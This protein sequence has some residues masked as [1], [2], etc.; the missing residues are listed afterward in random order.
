MV[1]DMLCFQKVLSSKDLL[2]ERTPKIGRRH[3]DGRNRTITI[4]DS[5]KGLFPCD[6]R[7]CRSRPPLQYYEVRRVI[8]R[9]T[10]TRCWF[11]SELLSDLIQTTMG[12]PVFLFFLF[13]LAQRLDF[14]TLHRIH[15]FAA[16]Y[17]CYYW[18][19]TH[20]FLFMRLR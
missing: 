5:Q 1:C 6:C 20:P 19:G 7:C 2:L 13:C 15:Y 18:Q 11:Q 9:I 8:S 3:N 4:L 14:F 10:R 12:F 17:T 16:C